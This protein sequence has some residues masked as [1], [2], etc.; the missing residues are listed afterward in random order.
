MKKLALSLGVSVLA[1]AV[2]SATLAHEHKKED[3]YKD[4]VE[5]SIAHKENKH[6]HDK[7]NDEEKR[8]FS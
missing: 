2:S 6:K 1:L 4:R 7:K 8:V 3:F 5:E